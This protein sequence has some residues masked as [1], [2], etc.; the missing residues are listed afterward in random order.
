MQ[1]VIGIF[2]A[3]VI[4][5]VLVLVHEAGH[6]SMAKAVG[7]RV[8]EF[9]I[10]MGPTVIQKEK[11]GTRY[12]IRALPIGGF[13]AMEGENE[14]SDLADAFNNKPAW[15]RALVIAA[16]PVMNFLLAVVILGILFTVIG[17]AVTPVV[18]RVE[19]DYPACEAG[20]RPGDRIV[21][22]DGKAVD[23]DGAAVYEEI[24][25]AAGTGDSVSVTWVRGSD[26]S[27][28]TATIPFVADE[29][30]DKKIGIQFRPEHSLRKGM[31]RGVKQS[32]IIEWE[33]LKALGNLVTGGGSMD[34]VS[35][36]VGVVSVI[37]QTVSV[38]TVNVLFLMALLS[39]NLGLINILPF[40]ALDGGRL[41]FIGIRAVTG[42]MITDEMEAK[43]H[44]AGILILFSLMVLI[45]VKD[46]GNLIF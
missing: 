4:F 25:D 22:I 24:Q 27:E 18:D 20:L 12:S 15:A 28:E 17:T 16:G 40:P 23:A 6:F 35:G 30:G 43:I 19:P 14:E 42:K 32:V 34:D 36:P 3:I 46:I 9:S 26:S 2:V 21:G 39:L 5:A 31:G 38:G 1:M 37:S 13:V 33:I 11:K 44:Y 29:S 41:L 7:I 45:T 8:N 10:G